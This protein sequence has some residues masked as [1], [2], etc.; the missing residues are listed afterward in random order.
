[1]LAIAACITTAIPCSNL[2][3]PVRALQLHLRLQSISSL[4]LGDLKV[5][6]SFRD[7]EA[8]ELNYYA[9]PSAEE[10]CHLWPSLP[11]ITAMQIYELHP[12]IWV[13]HEGRE[14][15]YLPVLAGLRGLTSLKLM[16][17]CQTDAV[18]PAGVCEHLSCL[19]NLQHLEL[20]CVRGRVKDL[21][22]LKLWTLHQLTYLDLFGMRSAVGD[23]VAVALATNMPRLRHLD[24][25]SCS[26]TSVA[27][28]PAIARLQHLTRLVLSENC[29]DENN[30][31]ELYATWIQPSRDA[32]WRHLVVRC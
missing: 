11:K 27:A 1:M 8:L 14:Q 24:L 28:L 4:G 25:T 7:L 23:T 13:E 12:E 15:L 17:A 6:S 19:Q 20:S 26:I 10:D 9:Y 18:S 30:V 2:E 31:F 29:F 32:S 21:D 5:R 16:L 22:C 3:Q